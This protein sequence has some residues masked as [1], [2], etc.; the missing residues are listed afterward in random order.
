MRVFESIEVFDLRRVLLCCKTV[1]RKAAC[2]CDRVPDRSLRAGHEGKFISRIL[3][4]ANN[5][6]DRADFRCKM[7]ATWYPA[8][9]RNAHTEFY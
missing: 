7:I 1:R 3:Q 4:S 5:A 6:V 8:S 9:E 2:H